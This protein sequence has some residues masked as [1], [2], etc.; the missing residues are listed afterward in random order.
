MSDD[1]KPRIPQWIALIGFL[2]VVAVIAGAGSLFT[3]M[4]VSVWYRQL[5]RPS[6]TPPDWLFGPVWTVL[7]ISMAVAAWLIWKRRLPRSRWAIG[8]WFAQL[9]LNGA[10][11]PVFFGLHSIGG[12][13]ITI[14]LLWLAILATV[15][16][17]WPV[18]RAAAILMLP[19]LAWV[20]FASCLNLALWKLNL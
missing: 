11:S 18:S 2:L 15:G 1:T 20:T 14:A 19:Y 4:G 5:T 6:W 13:L 12:G 10:W 9:L 17:F 3:S 8:V 7:Y 16:V